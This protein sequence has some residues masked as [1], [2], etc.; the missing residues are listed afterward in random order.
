MSTI[1]DIL[2]TKGTAVHC[3]Q[4]DATIQDAV[5][6]MCRLR[7]GALIV[8]DT[9]RRPQGILSERDLMLRVLLQSRDPETTKVGDVMTR[10]VICVD[11][12]CSMLRAM[13][14]MTNIPC[15][16]LP[17]LDLG[18]VVGLISIGDV[19]RQVGNEQAHELQLVREYIEGRY[20]G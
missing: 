9:L 2:D 6:E 11:P 18:R 16:H 3:I 4:A 5:I 12:T 17:V 1:Q 7:V 15:R 8:P 14:L 10:H 13:S 19:M 20:P